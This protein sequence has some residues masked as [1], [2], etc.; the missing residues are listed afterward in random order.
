MKC[1]EVQKFREGSFAAER[2]L[3]V[4]EG[5]A[6][7]R[8][9]GLGGGSQLTTGAKNPEIMGIFSGNDPHKALIVGLIVLFDGSH[10]TDAVQRCMLIIFA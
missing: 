8:F 1:E 5:P 3:K 2:L 9:S 7:C 10:A 6:V 4:L